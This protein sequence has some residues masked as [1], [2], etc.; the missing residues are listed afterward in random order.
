[1]LWATGEKAR[2]GKALDFSGCHSRPILVRSTRGQSES[3][4]SPQR[5]AQFSRDFPAVRQG[6][7]SSIE[8]VLN[9]NAC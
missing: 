9:V 2:C 3:G 1:M 5:K 4:V 6:G 7:T 8:G